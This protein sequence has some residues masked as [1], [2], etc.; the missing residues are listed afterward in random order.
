MT[1]KRGGSRCCIKACGNKSVYTVGVTYFSFPRDEKRRREWEAALQKTTWNKSTYSR[2]CSDHF[3][4]EMLDIRTRLMHE[5]GVS[6]GRRVLAP[7]A[8]PTLFP[9]APKQTQRGAFAKRR[10]KEIVDQA[11]KEAADGGFFEARSPVEPAH[12]ECKPLESNAIVPESVGQHSTGATG[13]QA[14]TSSESSHQPGH[15]VEPLGTVLMPTL[16]LASSTHC[17]DSN[18]PHLARSPAQA[19]VTYTRT[20]STQTKFRRTNRGTQA[21]ATIIHVGTATYTEATCGDFC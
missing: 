11:M 5:L 4:P 7:H 3:T 16:E 20:R 18:I 17:E 10:R 9:D 6:E 21:G 1:T 14:G 2:I 12:A 8:V 15:V 13:I 19:T